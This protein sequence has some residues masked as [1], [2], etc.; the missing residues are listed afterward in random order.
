MKLRAIFSPLGITVAVLTSYAALQNCSEIQAALVATY[1]Q[2]ALYYNCLGPLSLFVPGFSS[3]SKSLRTPDLDMGHLN[4]LKL[5]FIY[6]LR[7]VFRDQFLLKSSAD[8]VLKDIELRL[9]EQFSR[10]DWTLDT[11][12]ELPVPTHPWNETSPD[13]IFRDYVVN[14]VPVIIKGFPSEAKGLWNPSYFETLAGEHELD[15]INTSAVSSVRMKMS[16]YV[17]SQSDPNGHD[18][19]YIRAWSEI[20]DVEK[21]LAAEVGYQAFNDHLKSRFLTAQ[22]FMGSIFLSFE[23]RTRSYT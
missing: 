23:T 17:A 20:F 11:F 7:Y 9:T 4:L 2:V 8:T 1:M 19:L 18:I 5:Q 14:G 15:V 6:V 3:P 22:I 10:N 13:E 12:S 21:N 16:Q